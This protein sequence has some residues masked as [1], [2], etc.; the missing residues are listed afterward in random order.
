MS[1]RS[2]IQINQTI[3]VQN[4]QNPF[5]VIASLG[6]LFMRNSSFEASEIA[7]TSGAKLNLTE[8]SSLNSLS[9]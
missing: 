6:N 8:N 2:D 1:G 7:M 5:R 4:S 3:I 9:G